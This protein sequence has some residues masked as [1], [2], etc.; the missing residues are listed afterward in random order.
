MTELNLHELCSKFFE[1]DTTITPSVIMS[2][3]QNLSKS[4]HGSHMGT[5][6]VN[7]TQ[8]V[9]FLIN[10]KQ[11]IAHYDRTFTKVLKRMFFDDYDK[12]EG[13][14]E[15]KTMFIKNVVRTKHEFKAQD[16]QTF[17]K[18]SKV[19]RDYYTDI[20][21]S[22]YS[23]YYSKPFLDD[24]VKSRVFWL[25]T[26]PICSI[27]KPTLWEKSFRMLYGTTPMSIIT[28]VR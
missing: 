6:G 9:N 25:W 5:K 22:M 3:Q 18:D 4:N 8:F 15:C 7:K 20:I 11:F 10:S 28:K 1:N 23:F 12:L 19:Y 14:E 27:A 24:V 16:V 2:F 21:S 26:K 17:M 13:I